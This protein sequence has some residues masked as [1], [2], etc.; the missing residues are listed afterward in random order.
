MLLKKG[1]DERMRWLSWCFA[2]VLGSGVTFDTG[3]RSQ[4]AA[5]PFR[6]LFIGNSHTLV[7]DVADQ[8]RRRLEVSRGTA[9][10]E[11]IAKG[12]ARLSSFA[13]RSDVVSK[14]G[15]ATWDVVVLQEA[16]ATF[17]L[18]DG[19]KRFHEAIDWFERQIPDRTRIVLYQT[20]PWQDDS[21]YL[22]RYGTTSEAMW[23]VMQREYAKA[24]KRGRIDVAPVGPCWLRSPARATFYSA[25]GNHAS[26]AGSRLAADVIARTIENESRERC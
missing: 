13:R 7:N 12:G 25:D 8:V 26:P 15:S 3:A 17:V 14:L 22:K 20:W 21:R 1:A 10:V 4:T 9:V 23:G 5:P 18:P 16:S 6:V 11:K 24:G 19:P 2:L